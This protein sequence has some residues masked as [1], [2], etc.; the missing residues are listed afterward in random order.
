M[1]PFL[2]YRDDEKDLVVMLN[3]FEGLKD[4]R[5]KSIRTYLLIERDLQT[6]LFAM[7]AG[8]GFTAAIVAR[9]IARRQITAAGVLNPARDVP[10][11][12][13]MSE[14]SQRG[15][16]VKEEVVVEET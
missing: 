5:K 4:G 14:L 7:S 9:M 6:G 15:I 1:P 10:Y 3:R 11:E 16:L 13:F 12:A 8:V 2:Q